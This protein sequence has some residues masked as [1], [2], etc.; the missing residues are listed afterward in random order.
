MSDQQG[1]LKAIVAQPDDDTHRLVFA[2][3][4]EENG[5]LLWADLIRGQCI[6]ARLLEP[7]DDP[8]DLPGAQKIQTL[9]PGVRADLL[10]PF[11][12]LR[13][14]FPS[15][16]EFFQVLT[17]WVRRGMIEKLEIHDGVIAER[18][19]ELAPQ[20]LSEVPLRHLRLSTWDHH[21]RRAYYLVPGRVIRAIL[22]QPWVGNLESLDLRELN[23]GEEGA[24]YLFRNH[25]RL[26]LH[27]LYLDFN[28][29]T[30]ADAQTLRTLFGATLVL[31][32]LQGPPYPSDDDIPF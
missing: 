18:F 16:Q 25:H 7:S 1:I 31:N 3:W 19:A 20:M 21:R 26:N 11:A 24:R 14:L 28:N 13:A 10:A 23:L 8:G 12:P 6:L 2:D 15:E 4:L 5:K 29:I 30:E 17:F 22:E 9:L 32:A 27:R